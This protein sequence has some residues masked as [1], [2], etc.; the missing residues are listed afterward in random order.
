[1]LQRLAIIPGFLTPEGMYTLPSI[2]SQGALPV[3]HLCGGEPTV[4]TRISS[5]ELIAMAGSKPALKGQE[6]LSVTALAGLKPQ[7]RTL[8]RRAGSCALCV[9]P[10]DGSGRCLEIVHGYR[11]RLTGA[12]RRGS[13]NLTAAY[14]GCLHFRH[15]SGIEASRPGGI[16][17]RPESAS[18]KET[19]PVT[20]SK[21]STAGEQA[22]SRT[23]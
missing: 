16:Q 21:S 11:G 1:M 7:S 9:A 20:S 12:H 19:Q 13:K 17:P 23:L 10:V 3:I 5:P 15:R 2:C 6:A 14:C 18:T 4:S 8:A 22:H